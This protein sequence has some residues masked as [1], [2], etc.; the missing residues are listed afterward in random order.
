[1]DSARV[2]IIALDLALAASV[3][4]VAYQRSGTGAALL[5]SFTAALILYLFSSKKKA[6]G[7]LKMLTEP[8]WAALVIGLVG[9]SYAALQG[10]G[11]ADSF[12]FSIGSSF[13]G[14]AMGIF[15]HSYWNI[16]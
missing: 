6:W 14:G 2:L 9:F 10:H 5:V 12:M 11:F 13:L 16:G 7:S 1:M 8:F 4:Y 3:G 15:L